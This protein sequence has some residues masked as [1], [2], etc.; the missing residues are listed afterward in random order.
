ML[1]WI[2]FCGACVLTVIILPRQLMAQ[3]PTAVSSITIPATTTP[4]P[5]HTSTP[6]YSVTPTQKPS[7]TLTPDTLASPSQEPTPTNTISGPDGTPSITPT[8]TMLPA[9]ATIS[10][11][12]TPGTA[13]VSGISLISITSPI[14]PGGLATISIQATANAIC[15]IS[16]TSPSGNPIIAEG[17]TAMRADNAGICSWTWLIPETLETGEA[18]L[19]VSAAGDSQIFGLIINPPAGTYP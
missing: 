6:I 16:F 9:S 3:F 17:L 5:T 7:R 12:A 14:S 2:I 11:S 8:H 19:L 10:G 1:G 13:T 18:H 4:R 15:Q